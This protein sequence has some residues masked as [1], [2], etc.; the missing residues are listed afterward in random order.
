MECPKCNRKLKR[1]NVSTEGA[2]SKILS[3]Q[4]PNGDYFDFDPVSSARVV[5]ELEGVNLSIQHKVIKLS[6]D[7]LGVY[8]GKDIVRS[9]GL[10]G[11]EQF[12]IAIPDKKHIVLTLY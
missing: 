1:V 5:K 8:F 9:L 11:G 12:D 7:R 6:K 10:K 3:W 4:C 2:K